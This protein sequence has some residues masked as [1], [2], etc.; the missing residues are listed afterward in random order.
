MA[1]DGR[2]NMKDWKAGRAGKKIYKKWLKMSV[3][4]V[5]RLCYNLVGVLQRGMS[6]IWMFIQYKKILQE[7][8]MVV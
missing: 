5:L 2:I 4:G 8:I 7:K 1:L 3:A 6:A